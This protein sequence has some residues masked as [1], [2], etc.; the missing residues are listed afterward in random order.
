MAIN[1]KYFQKKGGDLY[2]QR[3]EK[4]EIKNINHDDDP[5]IK[6]IRKIKNNIKSILEIGCSSGN[7]LLW[8]NENLNLKCYGIDPSVEAIKKCKK[9]N[10][11]CKVGTADKIPFVDNSFDLVVFPFS[12]M[13]F[14]NTLLTK[15]IDETYRVI[16]KKSFILIHDFYSKKIKYVKFKYNKKIKVRKLDNSRLFLWHPSIKLKEKLIYPVSCPLGKND[17][18]AVHL[19]NCNKK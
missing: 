7:R 10:L 14:D 3:K 18:A 9:K 1:K 13:Y 8:I 16:K 6:F 17:L 5:S 19:L 12:L 11:I 2:L 4:K 15:I